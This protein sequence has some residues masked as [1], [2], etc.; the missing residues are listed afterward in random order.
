[1]WVDKDCSP[2][3]VVGAISSGTLSGSY[4]FLKNA[5]ASSGVADPDKFLGTGSGFIGGIFGAFFAAAMVIVFSKYIFG[6]L[7]KSLQGI[8]NILFIPLFGTLTIAV[9][10]WIVNIALIFINLGLVLFL[11]I[12]E[13]RRE[14][15]WILGLILGAMMAID[16]GGYQL[17][18]RAYIFGTLTI[19][20]GHS[21]ISMALLYFW[22]GT[23]ARNF[24]INVY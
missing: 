6:K 19:A 8:K 20:N 5:I 24:I 17:I 22:Y 12:F 3:F 21:T 9:L 7:P 10:F 15:A 23:S 4:G 16:L 11:Q 13:N 2:G 1:M 18:K 14:L